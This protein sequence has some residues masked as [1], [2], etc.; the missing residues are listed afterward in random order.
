MLV[1]TD[2]RVAHL[3][4]PVCQQVLCQLGQECGHSAVE[5]HQRDFLVIVVAGRNDRYAG[6]WLRLLSSCSFVVDD[7]LQRES[8]HR[9][10]VR[11]VG[12]RRGRR[13]SC[14]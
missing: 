3:H 10:A 4:L 1:E 12:P 14:S 5:P 9:R 2:V 6:S 7:S 13:G 11:L 8:A